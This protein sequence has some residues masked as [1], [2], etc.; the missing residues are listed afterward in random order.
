MS[1]QISIKNKVTRLLQEK[2]RHSQQIRE[3]KAKISQN[4]EDLNNLRIQCEHSSFENKNI[5][6]GHLYFQR[7]C[8]DCLSIIGYYNKREFG[9]DPSQSVEDLKIDSEFI[10]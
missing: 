6:E 3:L 8:T 2:E 7:I 10:D 9:I 4:H 5:T 1:K